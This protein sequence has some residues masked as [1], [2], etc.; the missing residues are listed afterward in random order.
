MPVFNFHFG[1]IVPGSPGL[2]PAL[3]RRLGPRFGATIGPHPSTTK[4]VDDVPTPIPCK[5]LFDT[6][7]TRSGIDMKVAKSL[8]LKTM[9]VAAVQTAR[10]ENRDTPLFAFSIHI[11]SGPS[12][13]ITG[14]TG[15]DLHKAGLAAV[16]GMDILGQCLFTVNGPAGICTLAT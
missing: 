10:G 12:F 5:V 1:R 14:G 16:I 15:C 8:G 4:D 3:L 9:G 11:A 6:G 7:A 2:G 13:N